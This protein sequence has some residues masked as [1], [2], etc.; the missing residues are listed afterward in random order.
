MVVGIILK[1]AATL[2]ARY[3]TPAGAYVY[4]TLRAQDHLIRQSYRKSGLYN[5]GVV[6]G[7][8][9][10]NIAGQVIGGIF[11]LGLPYPDDNG[12]SPE[13]GQKANKQYKTRSRQFRNNRSKY[14]YCPRKYSRR[15]RNI[16]SR[17]R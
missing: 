11:N 16:Y 3:G 1:T 10:G 13:Y 14:K 17:R 5:R 12:V 2:V 15:N 6:E 4:K 8:V 9:H 7:V